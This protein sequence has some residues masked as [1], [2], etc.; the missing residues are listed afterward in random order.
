MP[1]GTG[2][3]DLVGLFEHMRSVGYDG[4]YVVEMEVADKENTLRYLAGAVEYLRRCCRT[5]SGGPRPSEGVEGKEAEAG[6]SKARIADE[7]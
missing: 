2:E 1:F 3:I 7:G 4:D 5:R 6:D